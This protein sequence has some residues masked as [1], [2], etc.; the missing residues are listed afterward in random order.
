MIIVFMTLVLLWANNYINNYTAGLRNT[1]FRIIYGSY[2]LIVIL[3]S[4]K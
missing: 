1:Y 4:I 3:C 2:F